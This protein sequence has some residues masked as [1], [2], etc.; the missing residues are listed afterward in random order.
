M[1]HRPT[2]PELARTLLQQLWL[3]GVRDVVLSP[4][5]RSAPLALALDAADRDGDLHLHVRVDERSAGFLALGLATGSRRPVAVV[6]TSGTA[7][8][9]LLPAVMEAHHTG[10]RLVVV[11]AD[12]PD[13]LR[14]TGANQTTAQAGIFGTFAPC[15]D[16]TAETPDAELAAAVVAAC[17]GPGPTQ[18]NLQLDGDLLPPDP[19]PDTWW[20]RPAP[21]AL[22]APAWADRNDSAR[23]ELS[24]ESPGQTHTNSAR[25]ESLSARSG[26]SAGPTGR[27]PSVSV[28]D[29]GEVLPT[30][31]RT[32]VVAGDDAGPAAR[33]LA[34]S[35]GWPLLA[36][37]TSGARIGANAIR[38]YRLLLST[39]LRVDIQ[40]VVVVGHPTLSR[41]VTSLL[42][43]R[44]IEV[45]AVRCA[46]GVA[47]DPGHVARVL[48]VVPRVD[49]PDG[50]SWLAA[51]RA[52]DA[53]LSALIDEG[54]AAEPAEALGL[55]PLAVAAAVARAVGAETTLVVG[56]SNP[57]R[58]LDVMATPWPPNE[59][60]FVVGNRGLAG[61]DGMVST[62]VGVA[63]GR[64]R[65][66]R[67]IAFMGDLTFLHDTNGLLVGRGQRRPSLTIVVLSDDGGAIFAT[68]E[69]GDRRY[70]SAFERVFGTPH[71]TDLE[72]LCAAHHTAYERV[73]DLRR[74]EAALAEDPRGLRVLEVPVSR[75]GRRAEAQWLR[76]LAQQVVPNRG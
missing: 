23:E 71:A 70:A 49:A 63:L 32:V 44:S 51:W 20:Q 65:A 6:T 28:S 4:G 10:R 1:A 72:A 33:L 7:V 59:R 8:G 61:I 15:R 34:E 47:T 24:D 62:A 55:P 13:R 74:L 14:G 17:L 57:V 52:A 48:D 16:L 35:A 54:V 9:N 3:G 69:Q 5:S 40:R 73:T 36:E 22:A 19:E 66:A 42:S 27:M 26:A 67:S 46:D 76:E 68:L 43:D 25:A 39:D 50:P 56:S 60:R 21:A 29:D 41:P 12:R 18:L 53:E 58:D 11:S 64:T 45:L 37:P 30:G 75:A 2:A 31:P 38:T